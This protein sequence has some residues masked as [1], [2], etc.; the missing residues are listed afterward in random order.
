MV[1]SINGTII[2][3]ENMKSWITKSGY[4]IFQ[5]LS[6]RGNSFLIGKDNK[7]ILID[8][9]RENKWK[10]LKCNLD[11]ILSDTG[12]LKA[13]ILTHTHFDHAENAFRIKECYKTKLIVHS[14]E[15]GFI[16]SGN[17]PTI[18]GSNPITRLL[19]NT[20]GEKAGEIYRYRPV[21]YDIVVNNYFDLKE[22]GFKGYIIHTPGH[23]SGSTS[24]IIDDEI[25]FVGDTLFGVFQGLV[26]PPFAENTAVLVTSW[27]KLLNTKCIFFLPGH[28]KGINKRLLFKEYQRYKKMYKL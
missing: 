12:S 7:F 19:T 14:E 16:R 9:G 1:K 10:E 11:K 18:K 26:S 24:I 21:S 25:A 3:G 20:V 4:R 15:A 8:T 6:G 23:T 13:L 22:L 27:G 28:G 17:N 2:K 5:V